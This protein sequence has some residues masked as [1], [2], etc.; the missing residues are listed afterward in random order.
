MSDWTRLQPLTIQEAGFRSGCLTC[1]PQPVM[2]DLEASIAVGFGWAGVTCDGKEVWSFDMNDD[3][4]DPWTVRDAESA[5]AKDPDRDWRIHFHGPL[6]ESTYQRHES[7]NWVL[8]EK[9]QG[10]A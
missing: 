1:G 3:E 7:N 9:G 4:S 2:I 10:F 6:S 5:A 8:V